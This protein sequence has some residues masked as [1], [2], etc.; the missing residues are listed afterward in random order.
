[1]GRACVY[2]MSVY[3]ERGGWESDIFMLGGVE[4]RA[5]INSHQHS[6]DT[7]GTVFHV[8]WAFFKYGLIAQL[9]QIKSQG[10]SSLIFGGAP[11][12][13]HI[14]RFL[15][16]STAGQ[17]HHAHAPGPGLSLVLAWKGPAGRRGRSQDCYLWSPE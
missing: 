14:T 12:E 6:L 8:G 9:L 3:A 11:C 15:T 7:S 17:L 4:A 1:M 13:V 16:Y 5:P 2:H 10:S